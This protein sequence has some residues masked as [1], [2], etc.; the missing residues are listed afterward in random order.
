MLL[1]IT[2]FDPILIVRQVEEK[3]QAVQRTRMEMESWG[4]QWS[5]A[6]FWN[7]CQVVM[8]NEHQSYFKP[9][10]NM[11]LL[12]V[13]YPRVYENKKNQSIFTHELSLFTSTLDRSRKYLAEF[14]NMAETKNLSRCIET[15]AYEYDGDDFVKSIKIL[16]NRFAEKNVEIKL[17]TQEYASKANIFYY[18]VKE[19]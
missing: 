12:Y 5:Y 1:G 15:D 19:K 17:R 9:I 14:K 16:D 18:F 2:S 10:F 4:N 11:N 6:E 7:L 8:K 3:E 13:L